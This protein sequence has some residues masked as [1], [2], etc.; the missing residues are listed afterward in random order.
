MDT[1]KFLILLLTLL[2]INCSSE[3]TEKSISKES[4]FYSVAVTS[5][6]GGIVSTNGGYYKAGAVIE[7]S[8]TSD[9]GYVFSEW[10]GI[11]SAKNPLTI[12]VESDYSI[13]AIF[14]KL[15]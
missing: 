5:S 7:I 1:L 3:M 12:Q 8:A 13:S 9:Q 14:I 11:N 15:E 2:T 10:M 4:V 6:E